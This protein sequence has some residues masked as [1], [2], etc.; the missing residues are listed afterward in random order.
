M[1]PAV[2]PGD[3]RVFVFPSEPGFLE[4]IRVG[5]LK[6]RALTVADQEPIV[7]IALFGGRDDG[8]E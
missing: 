3:K 2:A 5:A 6:V 1:Q 7:G 8:L 4:C